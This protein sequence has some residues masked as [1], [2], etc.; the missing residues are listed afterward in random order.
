MKVVVYLNQSESQSLKEEA[1]ALG[2]SLSM[3]VRTHLRKRKSL[4]QP[5]HLF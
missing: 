5:K 3:L 2:C 4:V 1:K